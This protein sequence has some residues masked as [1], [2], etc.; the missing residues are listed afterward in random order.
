VV[1]QAPG[2]WMRRY[3]TTRLVLVFNELIGDT[4]INTE[5]KKAFGKARQNDV[6]KSGNGR[7]AD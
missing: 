4:T 3:H 6:C 5:G 1:K 7:Q 2:S